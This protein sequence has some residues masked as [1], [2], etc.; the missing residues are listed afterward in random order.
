MDGCSLLDQHHSAVAAFPPG[1][2]LSQVLDSQG[3]SV[4]TGQ[5]CSRLCLEGHQACNGRSA[6]WPDGL[7]WP[8]QPWS[9]PETG[10][11]SGEPVGSTVKRCH[12]C[13]QVW[14]LCLCGMNADSFHSLSS[15]H[16][17]A[18][19][20]IWRL[21]ASIPPGN[22]KYDGFLAPSLTIRICNK[23]YHPQLFDWDIV[24]N[25]KPFFM[26]ETNFKN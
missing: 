18:L 8:L 1:K 12:N 26:Q 3:P 9:C 15:C 24:R 23:M 21:K 14:F 5:P 2:K 20:D 11:V 17:P 19:H 7:A 10:F 16:I 22:A 6:A 4:S 13:H 25:S